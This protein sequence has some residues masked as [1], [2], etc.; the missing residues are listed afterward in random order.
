[1]KKFAYIFLAATVIAAIASLQI[2]AYT[3][4]GTPSDPYIIANR[5][6]FTEITSAIENGD[7]EIA[8]SYIKLGNSL[9]FFDKD[10]TPIGTAETPFTGVFDGDGYCINNI[11]YSAF[12]EA[13][14][15]IA[16]AENAVIKNLGVVDADI[17]FGSSAEKSY[18]GFICG[19]FVKNEKNSD[20]DI[21]KCF[22]TG[23]MTV[24]A[25]NSETAYAGGIVGKFVSKTTG[26]DLTARNCY[27]DCDITVNAKESYCGGFAGYAGSEKSATTV[28]IGYLYTNGVLSARASL[29]NAYCGGMTGYLKAEESGWGEWMSEDDVVVL[30]AD[31]YALFNSISS[32]EVSAQSSSGKAYSS[33]TVSQTE[34]GPKASKLYCTG[35]DN[36]TGG[37]SG[38]TTSASSLSSKSFMGTTLGFD[39]KNVWTL[40]NG[41]DLIRKKSLCGSVSD[42]GKTV[43]MRANGNIN[44]DV[45]IAAYDSDGRMTDTK[46][47][48]LSGKDGEISVKFDKA[49]SKVGFFA[50]AENIL[51]PICTNN[52][53]E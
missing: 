19:S 10:F 18:C 39:L 38:K 23:S 12:G 33:Y 36:A 21:E 40:E 20:T 9:D 13:F 3:G 41:P 14:G 44:G 52:Y 27:A 7:A 6:D 31:S 32:C 24:V 4:T 45:F 2:F 47:R 53:V 37:I 30:S 34:S 50:F 17:V 29:K 22:A 25:M 16:Y 28:E 42:D 11:S 26:A 48:K 46:I 43:H 35:T 5:E 49:P 15:V 8:S 51:S 1:M